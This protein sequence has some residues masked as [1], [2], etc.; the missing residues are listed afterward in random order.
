MGAAALGDIGTHFSD[1]DPQYKDI[2]S[3]KLL[4]RVSEILSQN[5]YRIGNI[6]STIIAQE[7]RLSSYIPQ[8]RKN[9]AD[10]LQININAVSVKATT[11]EGT[12]PEGRLECIT[13][14]SVVLIETGALWN[15]GALFAV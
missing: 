14:R 3:I 8:M 15:I 13:A 12:G 2:S 4:T 5:G 10:A 9:I 7:P 6:D 1:S 11:P